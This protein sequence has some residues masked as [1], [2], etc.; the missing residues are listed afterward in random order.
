MLFASGGNSGD[1]IVV[2]VPSMRILKYIAVFTPEQWQGYGYDDDTKRILQEGSPKG[3]ML[4]WGDVHHPALSQTKGEYDGQYL[5]VNDKANARIAVISLKDF[6]THQIVRSGLIT[7]DHGG[8]FV[9]PNTEYVMEPAQYA[10]PLGNT[11]SPLSTYQQKYR[12]ANFRKT[13]KRTVG[14]HEAEAQ[15]RADAGF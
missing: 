10:A 8:A 7:D 6:S 1:V 9:T 4:T 14:R 2:G 3:A 11:Y 13:G 5:F 15:S 12:G